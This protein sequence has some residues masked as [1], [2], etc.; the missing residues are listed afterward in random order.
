MFHFCVPV[1]F[2]V[3]TPVVPI[4]KTKNPK[5]VPKINKYSV[6][7]QYY[8]QRKEYQ[9]PSGTIIQLKSVIQNYL[10]LINGFLIINIH[11]LSAAV[12]CEYFRPWTVMD[13]PKIVLPLF[14][15]YKCLLMISMYMRILLFSQSF[16]AAICK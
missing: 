12:V 1:C 3:F 4:A 5:W 6:V 14:L 16:Y 11:Q 10:Y 15:S 8:F 9:F 2:T 7:N 13:A